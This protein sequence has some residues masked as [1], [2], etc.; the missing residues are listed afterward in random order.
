MCNNHILYMTRIPI[1]AAYIF[2]CTHICA[3]ITNG[4]VCDVESHAP[5]P[6]AWVVLT[7]PDSVKQT[8]VADE[9]GLFVLR[10]EMSPINVEVSA[11]GYKPYCK[12]VNGNSLADTMHV[13]L[14]PDTTFLS[15]IVI[16]ARRKL[17]KVTTEGITYNMAGNERA[18]GENLLNS[19]NYVPLVNITPS[20]EMTVRG[21]SDFAIYLNGK[22]YEM[23]QVSPKEV[24][25]SIPAS[26]IERV[27]VITDPM[28]RY[29]AE[30]SPVI[31][32]I[33]TLHHTVD[34]YTLGLNGSG[35]TQPK[36]NGGVMYMAKSGKVE[37]SVHYKYNWNGQR[38]QPVKQDYA[39]NDDETSATAIDGYGDGD[40]QSHTLNGL[41]KW[42][43]DSVNTVYADVHGRLSNVDTRGIWRQTS[44]YAM[45]SSFL[46]ENNVWSGTIEGNVVYRNYYRKHAN[47]QRFMLGYRYTYNPDKRHYISTAFDEYGSMASRIRQNTDG[48]MNEHT[49]L[50]SWLLP[51]AGAKHKIR[52]SL[53]DVMRLGKTE[54][55]YSTDG[56]SFTDDNM[57][58]DQNILHFSAAASGN[59]L[60]SLHYSASLALERSHLNMDALSVEDGNF[61]RN[62]F[63]LLPAAQLIWMANDRM[64]FA[65]TYEASLTRPT[66][67][68][69]NPF[70]NSTNSLSSQE[71]N[72]KLDPEISHSLTLQSYVAFGAFVV[73]A[74]A[75]YTHSSDAIL[76]YKSG[77][78]NALV[79]KYGN[80]GRID[81]GSLALYFQWVPCRW[82]S[83]NANGTVGKRYLVSDGQNLH[84]HDWFCTCAPSVDFYLPKNLSL[85]ANY[86]VFKNLPSPWERKSTLHTYSFSLSKSLLKGSLTVGVEANSPF[87]KYQHSTAT[88]ATASM[89][90]R[91]TNYITARSFGIN[92]AYSLH[93]G[94]KVD[95][96]RD[97]SLQSSDQATGVR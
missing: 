42:T 54:S 93:K 23:A 20:G 84:Q 39:Y 15:E 29:S 97:N 50:G 88:T 4:K 68:M 40:W 27:E 45:S 65:L 92:V 17:T 52:F 63:N 12:S 80:V 44:T 81:R 56:T 74:S 46:N 47:L 49:I 30:T 91:Q 87:Q 83:L 85:S 41:F 58:Y 51:I 38:D 66:I 96:R 13:Y 31:L 61:S 59:I 2:I 18:K 32:N 94:K 24:L 22:P 48:G 19:L 62:S 21:S 86:G 25:Q 33:I 69:L 95:I 26:D 34:G 73:A 1:V 6:Y 8:A 60:P 53:R 11:I 77:T 72:P 64:Q 89:M 90:F 71:G 70:H 28:I 78:S 57:E 5:V 36:A 75:D 82:L 9:T 3:Q 55:F 76:S 7:Y 37:Y 10:N 43:A 79:T 16:S 14:S 35:Y 67:D